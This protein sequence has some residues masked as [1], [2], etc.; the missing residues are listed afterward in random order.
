MLDIRALLVTMS[1]GYWF[2]MIY[3]PYDSEIARIVAA[4]FIILEGGHMNYTKLMKLMY[5]LERRSLIEAG[6]PVVGGRYVAMA[7]GPLISQAY[8]AIKNNSWNGIQKQGYDVWWSGDDS[9][10]ED[11]LSEQE[12]RYIEEL[13]HR[14]RKS[15][16]GELIEYTHRPEN[17]PEW[18]K[19]VREGS[20]SG[21]SLRDI[22]GCNADELEAYAREMS[23]FASE[24]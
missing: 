17:C 3:F 9:E 4:R 6:S 22:P 21:I 2:D 10:V 23:L 8:D 20:S 24:E 12:E 7:N 13:S 18:S 5:L 14:F 11:Y 1:A 15:D 19:C 16:Y